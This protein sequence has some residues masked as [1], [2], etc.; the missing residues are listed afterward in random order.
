[1]QWRGARG[2]LRALCEALGDERIAAR[3]TRWR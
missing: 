3:V 2:E 1:L